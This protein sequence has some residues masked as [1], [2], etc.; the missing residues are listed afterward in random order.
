[1]SPTAVAPGGLSQAADT[2]EVDR[3]RSER[4]SAPGTSILTM[5]VDHAG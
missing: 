1:L 4:V 3:R 5:V 2:M